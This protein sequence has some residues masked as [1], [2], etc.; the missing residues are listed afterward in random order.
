MPSVSDAEGLR[1]VAAVHRAKGEAGVAS[2]RTGLRAARARTGTGLTGAQKA[3]LLRTEVTRA[4]AT[5]RS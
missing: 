1:A 5:R 4:Y 3:R 2:L